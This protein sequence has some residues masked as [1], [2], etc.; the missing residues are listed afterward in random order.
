[1]YSDALRIRYIEFIHAYLNRND[2]Y[3]GKT[4]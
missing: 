1:M 3:Q 4:T 2:N